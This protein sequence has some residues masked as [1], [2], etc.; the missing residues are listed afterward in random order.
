MSINDSRI[1]SIIKNFSLT[2]KIIFYVCSIIFSVGVLALIFRSASPLFDFVPA[3]GGTLVEGIIGNPSYINPLLST[4][5][6]GKTISSIVYSGLLK[7]NTDGSLSPDLASHYDILEDGLTYD[8]YLKEDITFH[9]GEPLTADDVVFTIET[10]KDSRIKSSEASNWNGVG[11][12]KINEQQ[13]RFHLKTAYAPFI[14]NLT[15]GILPKH[16]WGNIDPTQFPLSPYNFKP[17]G[18]G[19][20]KIVS[21]KNNSEEK[22]IE[23][24]LESFSDYQ[25]GAP[26][27]KNI[28]FVLFEN[29]ESAVNALNKKTIDSLGGISYQALKKVT[30][31]DTQIVSPLLL[32]SFAVFLNQNQ[33]PVLVNKEVRQ[34]LNEV[35]DRDLLIKDIFGGYASSL[36]S[37]ISSSIL[38]MYSTSTIQTLTET[39]TTEEE[40]ITSAKKILT[41]KGWE[42][43]ANGIMSKEIDGSTTTLAF[44]LTTTDN[45][46]LQAIAEILKKTWAKIGAQVEIQTVDTSLFT[47]EVITPRKY[48]ALLFGEVIGS[49]LDLYPFWH[50]SERNSPGLNIALYTNIRVDELLEK[51][52]KTTSIKDR[53]LL[54]E[55]INNK[56]YEDVPAVFL[57]SP[58]YLYIV[59]KKLQGL[60]LK[61]LETPS[62][63]FSSIEKEYIEKKTT[64][65]F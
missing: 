22:P 60:S 30:R 2:E 41:N 14:Y 28:S 16:I 26:Y 1:V 23:F 34:A 44:T 49:E 59:P 52:R 42:E 4:T 53:I 48:Q 39:Q 15:L 54:Y 64:L 32:R 61:T 62:D 25:G 55:E 58:Y 56:I 50:S 10:A 8:V 5:E 13:I 7:K 31:E 45:E 46:E 20:Y 65:K 38:E 3:R 24:N 35:V 9:D 21:V 19:P 12:E 6:S 29:E 63:R 37:P 40:R 36:S 18:S 17:V 27:I 11:V 51:G 57:Y 47:Q 33:S 43:N